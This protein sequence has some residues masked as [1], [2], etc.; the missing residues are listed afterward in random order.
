MTTRRRWLGGLLLGFL[1]LL[2][3]VVVWNS[4]SG[5]ADVQLIFVGYTN[6]LISLRGNSPQ[7]VR[8]TYWERKPVM[9]VTNSGSDPVRLL[10]GWE[11]YGKTNFG[12]HLHSYVLRVPSVLNP[13]ESARAELFSGLD[14]E[15]RR[16]ELAYRRIDSVE[17]LSQRSQSST[18]AA[19]RSLVKLVAG[20]RQPLWVHSGPFTNSYY[21]RSRFHLTAPPEEMIYDLRGGS[22][23]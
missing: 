16:A 9:L 5:R 8:D 2:I 17:R 13:G 7:S 19:L 10:T 14:G 18:N 20:S 3:A 21:R 11:A 23:P 6:V 12:V 4:R 1:C 15:I 22:S